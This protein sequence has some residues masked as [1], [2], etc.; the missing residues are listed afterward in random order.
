MSASHERTTGP[1]GGARRPWGLLILLSIAQFM[2]ILDVTVVNVAL[3]SIGSDLGFAP[4]DLQWVVTAYVLLTGGLLLLGGRVADML[5]RRPMFLTGLTVFTAASLASGLATSPGWLIASRAAQGLGAA[6]LS[7]AALSIVTSTYTG[8]QRTTALSAWGAI[9]A[10][11]GVVGLLFGGML[12]TWLSWEWV[13]F[14]NVPVGVATA[15]IGARM[16]PAI[17]GSGGLRRLDVAG[18]LTLVSGLVALV[19][20][21]EG[22]DTH[23]WGS[24]RTLALFAASAVLLAA[25]AAIERT[26]RQP[27]VPASTW[28]TRTLTSAVGLMLGATGFLIGVIF[29]GSLYLQGTLGYSALETGLAFMPLTAVIGV[30]AHVAPRLLARFGARAV[31]IGGLLLMAG[32][33]A[34]LAAAPDQGSYAPD[35]LPGFILAGIGI[36]LVFVMIQVTGM[37]EV[38]A[39]SAGLASGLITTAHEIGAALG[40]AVLSAV[41]A[42]AGPLGSA[43]SYQDG[44]TVAALVALG[45]AALAAAAV[46]AIRPAAPARAGIH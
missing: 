13:F 18:A 46:P 26:A 4:G 14:I 11:G 29:L 37:S 17:P 24:A 35:L 2:V 1:G 12:T 31:A 15:L 30:A 5:G 9:A 39:E 41:A 3:P 34:L 21:V 8:E 23:G 27:L 6:M 45:L 22:T 10:A 20:G 19:Y 7:P 42:A 16:L 33:A 28:R 38:R 44:L 40:V 32:A 36:G 43:S 25:F